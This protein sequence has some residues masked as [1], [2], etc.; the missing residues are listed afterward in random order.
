MEGETNM[1]IRRHKHNTVREKLIRFLER[2]YGKTFTAKGIARAA[3]LNYNTVR[4]ELGKLTMN[5]V[6][7]GKKSTNGY[8]TYGI[9]FVST[10]T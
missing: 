3:K 7:Y 10:I 4:K 1:R 8:K 2:N 5:I 6:H 9:D